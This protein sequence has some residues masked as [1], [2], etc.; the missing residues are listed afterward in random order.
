MVTIGPGHNLHSSP[1]LWRKD[2]GGGSR[3]HTGRPGRRALFPHTFGGIIK[4]LRGGKNGEGRGVV[5]LGLIVLLLTP[6]LRVVTGV[7]SFIYE[8]DPPMAIVTAFVLFVLIMSFVLSG[9]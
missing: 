6:I 1:R 2:Q 5:V 9:A 7:V 4:Y 3:Y 8:E